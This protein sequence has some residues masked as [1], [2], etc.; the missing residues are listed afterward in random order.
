MRVSVAC[1]SSF[2]TTKARGFQISTVKWG[3]GRFMPYSVHQKLT[4]ACTRPFDYILVANKVIEGD[5]S[6]YQGLKEVV[7]DDTTLVSLQ[8]GLGVEGPLRETFPNN[9]LISSIIYFSCRQINPGIIAQEAGIRS[10]FAGVA[11]YGRGNGKGSVLDRKRLA[12][13]VKLGHG[14][15][16]VLDNFLTERWSKQLW[17][18]AFN[19][20]C[21]ITGLDTR[22][23]LRSSSLFRDSVAKIMDET[24]DIA[25][26]AGVV[27]DSRLPQSLIE[28][29]ENAPSIVPSMLQ[30]VRAKRPME[31]ESLCGGFSSRKVYV[32]STDLSKI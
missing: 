12:E 29:T 18:G 27:L 4:E 28:I 6:L 1:R 26:A 32:S 5:G 22:Q 8:N 2:D 3:T 30:D 11:L 15:F 9:T 24:F 31:I 19:P 23:L 10:Y 21:A 13:F 17:N 14:D 16:Q 7:D 20:L 25:A